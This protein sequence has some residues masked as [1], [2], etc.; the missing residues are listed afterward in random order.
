M[1]FVSITSN[2]TTGVKT[3]VDSSSYS[4][5]IQVN[6]H[7]ANVA[8][9]RDKLPCYF[10]STTTYHG[11][12]IVILSFWILRLRVLFSEVGHFCWLYWGDDVLEL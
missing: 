4:I 3:A 7:F 11:R 8:K 2:C 10:L 1:V 5:K 6:E 9:G 12:S